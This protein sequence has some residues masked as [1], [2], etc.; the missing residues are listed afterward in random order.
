MCPPHKKEVEFIEYS[1]VEHSC[2]IRMNASLSLKYIFLSRADASA[3]NF[4]PPSTVGS[5]MS[6][7]RPTVPLAYASFGCYR[8][9]GQ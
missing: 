6:V 1:G 8:Q 9:K 2:A 3:F 5:R 4:S 7:C